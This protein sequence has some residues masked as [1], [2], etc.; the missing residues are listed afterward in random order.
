MFIDLHI[1]ELN[2]SKDSYLALEEI[3][4]IAKQHG[5]GAVCI[6][7]HDSMGLKEYAA[8]YTKRT[9]FPRV[10][11]RR[12]EWQRKKDSC[13]SICPECGLCLDA[14]CAEEVCA[15]KCQGHAAEAQG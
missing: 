8:E 1:H 15:E 5:L 10:S 13:E 2:Y 7:D 9:G 6:T 11:V 4:T 3:V 12:R 14:E